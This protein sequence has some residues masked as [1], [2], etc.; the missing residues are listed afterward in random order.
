M[1]WTRLVLG[2][3]LLILNIGAAS[4]SLIEFRNL[5]ESVK[6]FSRQYG[7]KETKNF[8]DFSSTG[9]HCLY[10]HPKSRI[11]FSYLDMSEKFVSSAILSE[12]LEQAR[13]DPDRYD[14]WLYINMVFAGGTKITPAFLKKKKS[15]R[16]QAETILHEDWHDTANLPYH[17]EEASGELIKI[18]GAATFL[19]QEKEL[20][21]RLKEKLN[22][23]NSVNQKHAELTALAELLAENQIPKPEYFTK[24]AALIKYWPWNEGITKIAHWHSYSYYF[25]L[26]YR[27]FYATGKD[28]HK[29]TQILLN[30]P[31][32]INGNAPKWR[33]S[34]K[35]YFHNTR[36]AEIRIESYLEQIIQEFTCPKSHAIGQAPPLLNWGGFILP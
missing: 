28:L 26:M 3:T 35:Q 29:F 11:P 20:D 16:D 36:A 8:R 10:Y 25:P 9:Q 23:E 15:Q 34:A 1:R 4:D 24:K 17:L 30:L 22:W 21:Q 19:G 18:A 31:P 33:G 7:F 5:A 12:A 6:Q 27:L 32:N 14:A 2:L 13:V